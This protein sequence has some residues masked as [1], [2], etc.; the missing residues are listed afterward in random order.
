MSA[1]SASPRSPATHGLAG[2]PQAYD[3]LHDE[4]Q[5]EQLAETLHEM[6]NELSAAI[7]AKSQALAASVMNDGVVAALPPPPEMPDPSPTPSLPGVTKSVS[8]EAVRGVDSHVRRSSAAPQ[9]IEGRNAAEEQG[10]VAGGTANL[11]PPVTSNS[12]AVVRIL[13]H[14]WCTHGQVMPLGVVLALCV[15]ACLGLVS[16]V[17]V[18]S[19]MPVS[20]DD[21]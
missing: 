5:L 1:L 19:P 15:W 13:D 4:E 14:H 16:A 6:R 7:T 20:V 9:Q 12:D 3:T 10:E 21:F 2:T 11:V 17:P 8:A 18:D